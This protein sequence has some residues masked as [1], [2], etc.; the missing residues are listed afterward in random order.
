MTR[1]AL[2]V[3]P[4]LNEVATIGEAIEGALAAQCDVLVVDDGSTD[5][6]LAVVDT[7]I[8]AHPN[9]VF[10]LCR[11]EKRGLAAAYRDGFA[12]G[13]EAGYEALG[14]MDADLSHDP[15]VIPAL[16]HGLEAFDLVIGS[17]YTKDGQT[18]DWPIHRKALSRLGGIYVRA[19]TAL[20]VQDPTAGYRFYRRQVIE[21]IDINTIETNGY[22]FQIE[23]ALRT[24]LSG[25]RILEVPITFKD[26]TY[27]ESKMNQAIIKEALIKV[28]KWVPKS[29]FGRRRQPSPRSIRRTHPWL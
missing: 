17:R 8:A 9:R 5:G 4:S 2:V 14:E 27:G 11:T 28:A 26:R 21:T 22:A 3:I 16:L 10:T 6:T 18:K 25:Y 20:P 13:L 24:W 23:M 29:M 19:L 1:P 7:L 15:R 12:W